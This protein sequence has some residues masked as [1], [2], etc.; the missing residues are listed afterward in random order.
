[1]ED[2]IPS[3]IQKALDISKGNIHTPFDDGNIPGV[4]LSALGVY[5]ANDRMKFDIADQAGGQQRQYHFFSP[6][7]H[8]TGLPQAFLGNCHDRPDPGF[9]G[10]NLRSDN[11]V[12]ILQTHQSE[13][14]DILF[15]DAGLA[16]QVNPALCSGHNLAQTVTQPLPFVPTYLPV[17]AQRYCHERLGPLYPIVT[18]MG[19]IRS[20]FTGARTALLRGDQYF[21]HMDFSK[22]DFAYYKSGNREID[23]V[24]WHFPDEWSDDPDNPIE[25]DT[26]FRSGGYHPETRNDGS[27][28]HDDPWRA[29]ATIW[30]YIRCCPGGMSPLTGPRP[31]L[32]GL[33]DFD[34]DYS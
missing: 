13:F 32:K 23:T 6:L 15:P 3:E 4:N 9:N 30:K 16:M 19:N 12:H 14:G 21:R 34:G 18:R 22:Q 28:H 33:H 27:G 2:L 1:M 8:S 24:Q 20:F 31:Q 17:P 7:T 29:V 11:P 25:A 5:S 26:D 10:R